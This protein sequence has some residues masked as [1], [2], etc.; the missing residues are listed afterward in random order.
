MIYLYH[1]GGASITELG[2]PALQETDWQRVK[3]ASLRLLRARGYKDAASALET[4]PFEL[5]DATNFFQDEFTV[6]KLTATL[7]Q[8]VELADVEHDKARQQPY[9]QIAETISEIGP[10][11]RF[12]V[13]QLEE[14][15]APLPV[16]SPSPRITTEAIESALADAE[17]L[18]RSRGPTSALDRAHTA[19]HG[20]LRAA[21]DRGGNNA[22]STASVTEL[23][24][25][26]RMMELVEFV[27]R[28]DETKRIIMALASIVDA[29][30]TLRNTAS[31]AH[32]TSEVLEAPEAM[33][34]IN[35]VRSLVHYLDERLKDR[36]TL[37]T[38]DG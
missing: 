36:H 24:K 5:I 32:P 37:S 29:A 13:M 16:A 4:Y 3:T 31:G 30:N 23:F 20:Y 1:G 33:L 6:L 35:A 28:A 9:C 12:I 38:G 15:D 27:S 8:Y 14:H 17:L 22:R 18:L 34:V 2:G 11:V 25:Q 10:Y 7:E 26:L 19:M 21:I